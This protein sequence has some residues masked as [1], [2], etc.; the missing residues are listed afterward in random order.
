MGHAR[1]L[2]G[3]PQR[4]QQVEVA[5]L[6]VRK[7]L[8]VRETEALVRRM[9]QPRR[10]A[11]RRRR[12]AAVDPN[13]RAWRRSWPRSSAPAVA[14]EHARAGKGRLVVRYN[15]LD[16]LDGILTHI[17]LASFDAPFQHGN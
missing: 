17:R 9:S 13:I 8:S 7:G 16:E 11:R 3:L 5:A 2:L 10:R 12:D 4:R 1:A 15:S 14:I 6:V